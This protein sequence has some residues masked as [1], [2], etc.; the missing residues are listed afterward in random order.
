MRMTVKS[1]Q[2]LVRTVRSG[3]IGRT[4][5]ETAAFA[6]RINNAFHVTFHIGN[7]AVRKHSRYR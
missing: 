4:D 6:C 1:G 2:V 5:D 7:G 3:G